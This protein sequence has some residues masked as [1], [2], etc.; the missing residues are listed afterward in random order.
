LN[1]TYDN[2]EYIIVDGG[3]TDK[4]TAIIKKYENR[5]AR[6][7]SE[8]DKGIYDAMNKGI[9]FARGEWVGI[10]N[11]DDWYEPD[12]VRLIVEAAAKNPESGVVFGDMR[13]YKFENGQVVCYQVKGRVEG[14][15]VLLENPLTHPTCFVARRVY[16]QFRFNP[17][18]R[19][20]AD[21]DLMARLYNSGVKFE[22]LDRI[23]TNFR[24]G[25]VSSQVPY[26][27]LFEA[28][29]IRS[30]YN[31]WKALRKLICVTAFFPLERLYLRLPWAF[32]KKYQIW[33]KGFR[34]G[35]EK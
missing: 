14:D 33:K 23:L 28:Y 34:S 3:S 18:F 4:T 7:V 8:P 29:Q 16:E 9:S 35:C 31:Q 13:V 2:I 30:R 1:Q 5:I 12:T 32:R 6:W 15:G 26:R 11:S 22:H 10:I 21:Y 25:G 27:I 17:V 19:M 24:V 20:G